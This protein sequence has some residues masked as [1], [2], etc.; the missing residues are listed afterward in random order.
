MFSILKILYFFFK[1]YLYFF[2]IRF[3]LY[4]PEKYGKKKILFKCTHLFEIVRRF[5][6]YLKPNKVYFLIHAFSIHLISTL[7]DR[8]P[9]SGWMMF[10]FIKISNESECKV[11]I[12]IRRFLEMFSLFW[13]TSY[14]LY[15]CVFFFRFRTHF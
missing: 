1:I 6:F 2:C 11:V 14:D 4:I 10:V 3:F 7:R 15:I 12:F 9:K 8:I 5:N 13:S